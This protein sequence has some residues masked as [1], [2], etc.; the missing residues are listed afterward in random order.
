MNKEKTVFDTIIFV[1]TCML[2]IFW[3][4]NVNYKPMER[5]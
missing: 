2:A 3:I 5:L 1:I 4:V